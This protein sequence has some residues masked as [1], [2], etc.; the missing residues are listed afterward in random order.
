MA[1]DRTQRFNIRTTKQAVGTALGEI[2]PEEAEKFWV[3]L[4]QSQIVAQQIHVFK[5]PTHLKPQI[6]YLFLTR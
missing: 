1:S 3:S 2:A 6:S 5:R 4:V